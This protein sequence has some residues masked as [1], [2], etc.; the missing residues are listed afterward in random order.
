MSSVEKVDLIDRKGLKK[1]ETENE[2]QIGG[3]KVTFHI[4]LKQRKPSYYADRG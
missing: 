1:V 2:K 3:F 4:G